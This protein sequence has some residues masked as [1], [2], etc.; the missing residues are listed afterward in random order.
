MVYEIE[1]LVRVQATM[2]YWLTCAMSGP[3]VRRAAS[4]ALIVGPLLIAIN[5]G[6]AIVTGDVSEG[7][8][9]RMTLTLLVPY[10]VS[11]F[12]SVQALRARDGAEPSVSAPL[13]T[14]LRQDSDHH[15]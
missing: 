9:L 1:L 8:L 4:C 6:D 11:T 10:A 5:H 7:R 2:R 13:Y 15:V 12:S 3:V 14:H